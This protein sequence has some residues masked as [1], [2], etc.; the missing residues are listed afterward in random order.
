MKL[1]LY[2]HAA[3]VADPELT[4]ELEHFKRW[5]AGISVWMLGHGRSWSI[6]A[7]R[8][9]ASNMADKLETEARPDRRP[10]L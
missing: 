2:G 10:A 1:L 3:E 8:D 4:E 9:K 7:L 5:R 6:E